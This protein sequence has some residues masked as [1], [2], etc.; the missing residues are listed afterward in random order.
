MCCNSV[1]LEKG[2]RG[3]GKQPSI[4]QLPCKQGEQSVWSSEPTF[5]S[6]VW[7]C[8]WWYVWCG[9]VMVCGMY[10]VVWY[11]GDVVC[12]VVCVVM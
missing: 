11:G 2:M 6:Q 8:V 9:G 3:P 12:V 5:T 10:G 4:E 1:H 7:W